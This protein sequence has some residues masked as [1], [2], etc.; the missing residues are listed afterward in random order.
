MSERQKRRQAGWGLRFVRTVLMFGMLAVVG[1]AIGFAAFIA[2]IPE[3]EPTPP[4]GDAIVV[5]TGGA[6]RIGDAIN[7]LAD[8]RARRLLISGVNPETTKPEIARLH[9]RA[10]R[11]IDCCVDL[12][13]RALNTAGNAAETRQWVRRHGFETIIVV[14]SGWHMRRSLLE[15]QRALPESILLPYPVVPRNGADNEWWREP[16]TIRLIVAEYVK[17]LAA[18]IEVRL[19]PRLSSDE[20]EIT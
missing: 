11:W 20:E 8:G 15:L 14:T 2:D 4:K 18:I 19:A 9:P 10:E 3:R 12:G 6:E 17:Y 7:L 16:R 1:L 5:L 13:R